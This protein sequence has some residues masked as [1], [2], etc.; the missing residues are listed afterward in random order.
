MKRTPVNSDDTSSYFERPKKYLEEMTAAVQTAKEKVMN[1]CGFDE[2]LNSLI[3]V[4]RC[5]HVLQ[6][7]FN[8]SKRTVEEQIDSHAY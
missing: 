4:T 2:T 3:S 5:L 7:I 6:S 1:I 8:P